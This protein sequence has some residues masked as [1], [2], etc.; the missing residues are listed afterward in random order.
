MYKIHVTIKSFEKNYIEKNISFIKKIQFLIIKTK[1][2]EISQK[3]WTIQFLKTI[4]PEQSNIILKKLFK[5]QKEKVKNCLSF[6]EISLPKKKKLF[7]VLR[8]PH[9]D[10]KSR[11]QFEFSYNKTRILLKSFSKRNIILFIFLLKN[12]DFPGVE[13]EISLSYKTPS[14]V[15]KL[16]NYPIKI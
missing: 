2:I 1:N 8:S 7:T 5:L 13:L 4:Y 10:K 15:Y 3:A 9:V 11:E 16:K 12:S 6:N 14:S